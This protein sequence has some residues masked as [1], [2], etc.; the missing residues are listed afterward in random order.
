MR[1]LSTRKDFAYIGEKYRL[2]NAK[3]WNRSLKQL[4]VR[5]EANEGDRCFAH[6]GMFYPN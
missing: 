1:G 4:C 6:F 2:L 5:A 3:R